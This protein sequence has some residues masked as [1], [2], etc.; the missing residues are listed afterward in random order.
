ML[1]SAPHPKTKSGF[2][3]PVIAILSRMTTTPPQIDKDQMASPFLSEMTSSQ[4]NGQ[5]RKNG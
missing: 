5:P 1:T 4:R 3:D 2:C